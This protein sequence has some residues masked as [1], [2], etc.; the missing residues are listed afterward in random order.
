VIAEAAQ[1]RNR[2][3]FPSSL[4]FVVNW[5]EEVRQLLAPR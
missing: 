4:R 1:E 2:R 3:I 5:T